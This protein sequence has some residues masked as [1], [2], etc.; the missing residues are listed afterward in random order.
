MISGTNLLL[1]GL[2][3]LGVMLLAFGVH[4]IDNSFNLVSLGEDGSLW[5]DT[6]IYGTDCLSPQALYGLGLAMVIVAFVHIMIVSLVLGSM[7]G[8]KK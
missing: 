3:A 1:L 7:F 8:V 4:N 2:F 6:L 5:C